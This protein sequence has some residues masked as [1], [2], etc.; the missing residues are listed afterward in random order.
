MLWNIHLRVNIGPD[1]FLRVNC[2][3]SLVGS[4]KH[5]LW[6]RADLRVYSTGNGHRGSFD[7]W[8]I[9]AVGELAERSKR[10]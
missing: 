8:N 10:N 7:H 3:C 6:P 9:K 2:F 1:V 4:F 5:Y